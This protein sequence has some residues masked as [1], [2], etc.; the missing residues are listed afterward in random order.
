MERL[1]PEKL[2]VEFRPGVTTTE[3]ILGRKYTLTHSDITAE[4]FLT[5]GLEFAHDKITTMRDEVLAEWRSSNSGLFL[6]VYVYV[7]NFG[8]T[9]NAIRNTIFRRELPL[10]LEAIVYG[11]NKFF[12]VHPQLYYAP[13]WIYFDSTD[14]SYNR[15]EYWGTPMDYK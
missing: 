11:D 12:T 15:F 3:P 5:I 8:S 4:L 1:D 7:G 10:A 14:Y 6:Y 2:S 9:M 13:I